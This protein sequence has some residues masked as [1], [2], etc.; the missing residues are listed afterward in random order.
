MTSRSNVTVIIC[1]HN[2]RPDYLRRTL[3]GLKAQ[4]L[5][6]EQWEF[7][8]IDNASEK[9]LADNWDLS[10]HPR[11]RHVRESA[12]GLTPARLCGIRESKGKLVVFVDDDNVLAR[13]YLSTAVELFDRRSDLGVASGCLM[14]EYETPPPSWF[15]PYESWI[16][17]RRIE[18]SLWSN[19]FEPRSE[20]CGA[21]M[22]LRRDVALD[23]AQKATNDIRQ[24]ILDRKGSSLLSAGDVAITKVALGLGYSMGQFIELNSVHLIP[25]RRVSEKYLFSLY[26]HL[27]A[28]GQLM[29][30]LEQ[31]GHKPMSLPNWRVFIKAALRL[32][33]GGNLERRLVVEEFR[34]LGLARRVARDAA[35]TLMAAESKSGSKV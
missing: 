27:Y 17:V 21:G 24:Q 5:P 12:L 35:V 29:S 7:L 25:S 15:R 18:Q 30:W 4:T 33:K 23:Y 28:S 16:A 32:I 8:L 2:P 34:A 26:R 1:T 20:P 9:A 31:P 22:C 13:D 3:D 10:W 6:Q 14:P 11:A 19:F